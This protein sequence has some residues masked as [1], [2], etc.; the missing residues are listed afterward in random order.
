MS[1][2]VHASQ[3]A[4][5]FGTARLAAIPATAGAA[6][7]ADE[8][9]RNECAVSRLSRMR[10]AFGAPGIAIRAAAFRWSR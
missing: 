9:G 3:A 7:V 10:D 1:V 8:H 4:K 2:G 5:G 6:A